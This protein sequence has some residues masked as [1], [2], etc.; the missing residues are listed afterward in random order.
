VGSGDILDFAMLDYLRSSGKPIIMSSGMST[1]EEV[2]KGLNFLKKKNERVALVHSL[3]K[4]PGTP[5][6]AN[7]SVIELYREKFPGTPIGFSENS[8]GIEPS[9]LAV[10]LGA[11]V[12]EKHLTLD[13]SLWGPDHKVS[14]T[15]EEFKVMVDY[16]RAMEISEDERK[17]WLS[18]VN[19][20]AILGPKEKKLK[21]DEEPLRPIWRKA[22]VAGEDIP[23][24]TVVTA[25]ALYAIRP[26]AHAKGLP[27][28]Q[29]EEVLGRKIKKDLKK[30]DPITE[31]V[32]E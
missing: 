3:T 5:E 13:R 24:G 20:E 7:L 21:P 32:L 10:A 9:C 1:F 11:T 18:H 19:L 26:F 16:I 4:Y 22:L 25:Q 30:F 23:V 2:E 28:E 29:Y 17:K 12:V 6:E 31:D 15:P 27:S 8:L 14:S